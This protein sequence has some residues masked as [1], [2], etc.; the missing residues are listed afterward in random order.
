M[1]D[2]EVKVITLPIRQWLDQY[3]R[4]EWFIES[5]RPAPIMAGSGLALRWR[6]IRPRWCAPFPGSISL[7]SR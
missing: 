1:Y 7:G 4:P 3:Y 2:A 6:R 5:V